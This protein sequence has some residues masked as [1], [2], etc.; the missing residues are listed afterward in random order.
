MLSHVIVDTFVHGPLWLWEPKQH[1]WV[2]P[3][4]PHETNTNLMTVARLLIKVEV[5]FADGKREE[6]FFDK[7]RVNRSYIHNGIITRFNMLT[8]LAQGCWPHLCEWTHDLPEIHEV[9]SAL[10]YL[11]EQLEALLQLF[12]FIPIQQYIQ[13]V[14]ILCYRY[15]Y[16]HNHIVTTTTNQAHANKNDRF[17]HQGIESLT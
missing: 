12:I 7:F 14:Q 4:L 11:V 15:L 3:H 17:K 16:S 13:V 2:L 9:D 6:D 1:V 10:A 5:L 8:W